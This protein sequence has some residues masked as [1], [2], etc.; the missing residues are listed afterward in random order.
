MTGRSAERPLMAFASPASDDCRSPDA[1]RAARLIEMANGLIALASELQAESVKD[2]HL[3]LNLELPEGCIRN[4]SASRLEAVTKVYRRRSRRAEIFE[5][6]TLFGEP[7]WDIL[8]DLYI[9]ALSDKR[10]S[11]T[12]ACIASGVPTTTGLRWINILERKGLVE[13]HEDSV[14]GRRTFLR[15]TA[16]SVA[17]MD[18]YFGTD[19]P[20]AF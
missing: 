1:T 11:V 15:L 18:G 3:P 20:C 16:K 9:A 10:V 4:V 19:A 13:R 14:D 17:L 6:D 8:L 7:S 5:D 12:S 2:L